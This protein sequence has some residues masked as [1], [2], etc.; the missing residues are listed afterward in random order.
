[1]TSPAV[2]S[3][4]AVS[5]AQK[6]ATGALLKL[7]E[8]AALLGVAPTTVHTLPL[9]SIRLGR[10]LRFDPQDVRRLIDSCREPAVA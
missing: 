5:A 10:S 6:V 7:D 8:V 1:M 9:A 3:S 2:T 4:P